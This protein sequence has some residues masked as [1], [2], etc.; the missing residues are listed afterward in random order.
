[1]VYF[2]RD[3]GFFKLTFA[4]TESGVFERTVKKSVVFLLILH[5]YTFSV[6]RGVLTA[7]G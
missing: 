5:P 4:E 6:F 3:Y 2:G 7:S 1:M